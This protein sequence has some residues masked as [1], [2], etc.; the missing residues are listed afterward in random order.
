MGHRELGGPKGPADISQGG[1]SNGEI[2][3]FH[4]CVCAA[5]LAAKWDS[6]TKPGSVFCLVPRWFRLVVSL[7][8]C[9]AGR[10]CFLHCEIEVESK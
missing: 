6:I 10:V 3:A 9:V 1:V 5:L 2:V 7:I 8:P 4:S